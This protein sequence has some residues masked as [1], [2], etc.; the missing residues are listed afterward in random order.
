MNDTCELCDMK[1]PVDEVMRELDRLYGLATT[2]E[3]A[4]PLNGA[5]SLMEHV[6]HLIDGH[7]CDVPR[8][9]GPDTVRESEI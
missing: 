1:A 6:A 8:R 4:D 9:D 5:Y 3:I 2:V 7:S